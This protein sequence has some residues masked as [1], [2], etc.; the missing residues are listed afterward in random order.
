MRG[1]PKLN[2]AVVLK[3]VSDPVVMHINKISDDGEQCTCVWQD[4]IGAP[5]KSDFNT[6]I[7]ES[8]KAQSSSFQNS[9]DK[10]SLVKGHGKSIGDKKLEA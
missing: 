7:L 4:R 8:F 2:Q 10:L 5:Y 3:H 6:D 1:K 9:E